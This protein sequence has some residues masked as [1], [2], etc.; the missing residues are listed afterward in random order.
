MAE[1]KNV[2]EAAD[3]V[4]VDKVTGEV[5][6]NK[7]PGIPTVGRAEQLPEDDV[8]EIDEQEE[9]MLEGDAQ[10]SGVI[11]VREKLKPREK[12][13]KP[14]FTYNVYGV[15]RGT[16]VRA[17]MNPP[18]KGGFAVLS[19]VFGDA[20]SLPLYMVPYEM[21]DEKGVKIS[22]F[23][24]KVMSADEDGDVLEC[25]VKPSR[26]SDKRILDCLIRKAQKQ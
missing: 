6:E 11:L 24:Y 21:K 19:L 8:D 9:E 13:A 25:K 22:G 12:G 5:F 15:V 18:D 23:T 7:K 17:G 26:D 10:L 4:E 14:I 1:K 20:D 2:M 16:Q 3:T